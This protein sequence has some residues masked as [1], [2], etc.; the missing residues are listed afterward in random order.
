MIRRVSS[1][2]SFAQVGSVLT[3]PSSIDSLAITDN[4][5]QVFVGTPL[6][7]VVRVY[8]YSTIPLANTL[9]LSDTLASPDATD[10]STTQ[11]GI[12]LD[13][14]HLMASIW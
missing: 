5:A 13:C 10:N 1:D 12:S 14:T 11:F 7:G 2:G 4:G 8:L 6:E 3:I 9:S